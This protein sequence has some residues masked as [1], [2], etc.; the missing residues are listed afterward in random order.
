MGV[1]S[2]PRRGNRSPIAT[3]PVVLSVVDRIYASG[4][5]AIVSIQS[6]WITWSDQI[7][8]TTNLEHTMFH[9]TAIPINIVSVIYTPARLQARYHRQDLHSK[10]THPYYAARVIASATALEYIVESSRCR[11]LGLVTAVARASDA[12]TPGTS[13]Y[14]AAMRRA[15]NSYCILRRV[16]RHRIA[17]ADNVRRKRSP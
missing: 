11:L 6:D 4:S 7:G 17:G 15:S 1:H 13:C 2:S 10:M 3:Q 12:T 16:G 8:S 14:I 9:I 5:K